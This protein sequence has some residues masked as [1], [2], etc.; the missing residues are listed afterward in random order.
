MSLPLIPIDKL[1]DG[2]QQVA[3]EAPRSIKPLVQYFMDE[4]GEIQLVECL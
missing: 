3:R 4:K 1:E 2:F